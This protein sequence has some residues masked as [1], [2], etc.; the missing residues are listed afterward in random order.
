MGG[1]EL[2]IYLLKKVRVMFICNFWIEVG[3]CNGIMGIIKDII[4]LESYKVIMLFIVIIVQFDDDYLGLS[5]C[6]DIFNCVFI[7]FVI[8]FF[9]VFGNNFERVQFL[10]KFVWLMIIYKL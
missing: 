3:F 6:K 7:F 1:L 2:I 4:F 9:N 5:F 10:L 8:S